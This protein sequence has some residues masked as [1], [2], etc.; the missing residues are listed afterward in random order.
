MRCCAPGGCC[1]PRQCRRDPYR[2]EKLH[3]LLPLGRQGTSPT[4][5]V[6]GETCSARLV[7][8]MQ[9]DHRK[10]GRVRQA[11][12]Y[13]PE[14]IGKAFP[15]CQEGPRRHCVAPG[16][17]IPFVYCYD[18]ARRSRKILRRRPGLN[19][20][21]I[22]L[23]AGNW[24]AE[25]RYAGGRRIEVVFYQRSLADGTSAGADFFTARSTLR[26]SPSPSYSP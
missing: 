5:P 7:M 21:P 8:W 10:C 24:T 22:I 12:K 6:S 9:C 2:P 11:G 25:K 15:L 13:D 14:T 18:T 19:S 4:G 1:T 17:T 3:D 26:F 23:N 16:V 20:C